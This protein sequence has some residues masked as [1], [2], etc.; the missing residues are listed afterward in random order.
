MKKIALVSAIAIASISSAQAAPKVYGKIFLSTDYVSTDYDDKD[1]KD[2][3]T[4]KLNSNSSRIGFRGDDT[5]NDDIDLVYQLEYEINPDDEKGKQFTSRNTYLGLSNRQY[6][7]LLA[8]RHD[9]PFKLSKGNVD[10]FT[11]NSGAGLSL[12]K[13]GPSY[14]NGV[15]D[16]SYN[17]GETRAN[18]VIAYKTPA[19]VGM[20]VTFMAAVSLSETDEDGKVKL[21]DEVKEVKEVK[22]PDGTVLV[23]G[24]KAQP[25]VYSEKK[26]KDNGYSAMLAYDQNG[27]YLA[28]GYDSN[29]GNADSAW[30]IAGSI[31]LGKANMMNGM[32]GLVLGALYQNADIYDVKDDAKTWL[33]SGKYK[34]PESKWAIKAQYANT[35]FGDNDASEI[36]VG[37]E[38][39]FSK[40][41]IGHIYAGQVDR[42]HYKDDTVIGA[43]LEYKF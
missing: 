36:A 1:K 14:S 23:K 34:L 19:I 29:V 42:D 18:N 30:R 17:L 16:L 24:V 37:G 9:T 2:E 12:D 33:V 15:K 8:G 43:G 35:D 38:Y 28:G 5:L 10:V 41:A 4:F 6:G 22:L 3:D 11:N 21:K 13:I 40:A 26:I 20:P 32:N 31:D 25:A 27:M 39:A 7:T